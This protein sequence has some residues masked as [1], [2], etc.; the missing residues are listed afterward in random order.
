[1][2]IISHFSL[3]FR[4]LLFHIHYYC[5]IFRQ[6]FRRLLRRLL[7]CFISFRHADFLLDCFLHYFGFRRYFSAL[8]YFIVAT[9]RLLLPFHFHFSI[10]DDF[11]FSFT[12]M[13]F[14]SLAG[15]FINTSFIFFSRFSL[16]RF[17]FSPLRI[18]CFASFR[19]FSFIAAITPLHYF[20]FILFRWFCFSL[21]YFIFRH[22]FSL[23][24]LLFWCH[25]IFDMPHV[26]DYWSFLF[27]ISH[28]QPLHISHVLFS[29][30]FI[31]IQSLLLFRHF[32]FHFRFFFA[33]ALFFYYF[34]FPLIACWS[35]FRCRHISFMLIIIFLV[36]C[37]HAILFSVY[38]V[39]S[40]FLRHYFY[41]IL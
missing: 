3:A 10:A 20:V 35:V 14:S 41:F 24:R 33:S 7:R 19:L 22:W 28:F 32:H 27:H 13:I 6:I 30:R 39:I 16:F 37:F 40:F 17:H 5:F 34:W 8:A 31:T 23:L 36:S 18:T 1:M 26:F 29:F 2:D 11:L 38:A 4:R 9:F 12:L 25:Y 21:W 15:I